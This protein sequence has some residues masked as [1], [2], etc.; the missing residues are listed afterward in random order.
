MHYP[1]ETWAEQP[2]DHV[3]ID[4]ARLQTA[5]RWLDE[6][7][8]DH[9]YRVVIVRD[10]YLIAEW[11]RGHERDEQLDLASATKSIFSSV[12]G[13]VIAEGR[14]P[15]A[16]AYVRDY[17]PE[18]FT[19]GEHEGPKPGRYAF[20]K[21]RDITFRQLISNTSGYMKP[22]ELPGQV[23]HY[24]TYGMNILTHALAT[25]YGLYDSADPEGSPGF[26]VLV[27]RFIREPIGATW[28]YY[29]RNFDLWS[30]ARINVFG[31]YDGVKS[32]ARDMARLG[33][34]WCNWGHWADRQVIPADWLRAATRTA[35][36]I[37]A[38]MPESDWCYGYGFWTNDH[39]KLVPDLPRS[40]FMAAGAGK[41]YIWVDPDTRLVIVQSPGPWDR[42]EALFGPFLEQIFAAL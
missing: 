38:H 16:D 17:Y 25:I 31:Y 33:W 6:H 26:K 35:P 41:Q 24:Q 21:D 12:L 1:Q 5:R 3:G 36:A 34:L 11:N 30:N 7:A 14:L 37:V 22:D 29:L 8:A 27:E 15:S 18:A 42:R 9:P 10:G 19:I 20:E 23:F 32:T 28:G 40:C 39:G 2:P 4:P 13:I